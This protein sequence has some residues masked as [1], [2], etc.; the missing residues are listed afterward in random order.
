M[1]HVSE[2]GGMCLVMRCAMSFYFVDE[3][4]L[5]L[6]GVFGFMRK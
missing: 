6:K 5:V 1:M 4:N 2:M 3:R